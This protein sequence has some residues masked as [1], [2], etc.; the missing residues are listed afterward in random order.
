MD[1]RGSIT[2]EYEELI[3]PGSY[4]EDGSVDLTSATL[5]VDG[6]VVP[7]P[8]TLLLVSFGAF[9]VRNQLHK[10]GNYNIILSN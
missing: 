9:F 4:I 5:V 7:E 3:I 8:T 1:G 6:V 2:I 10:T